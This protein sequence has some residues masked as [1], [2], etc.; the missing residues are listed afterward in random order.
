M[1]CASGGVAGIPD[2]SA[3]MG[4]VPGLEDFEGCTLYSSNRCCQ[5]DGGCVEMGDCCSNALTAVAIDGSSSC[6]AEQPTASPTTSGIGEAVLAPALSTCALE[7][8]RSLPSLTECID[9]AMELG[10]F[11]A[12]PEEGSREAKVYNRQDQ[13]SGCTLLQSSVVRFNTAETGVPNPQR[14]EICRT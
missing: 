7:G 10:L 12:R 11:P 3:V 1:T 4:L 13:P 2:S 14:V 9:A 5:C 6:I 8:L